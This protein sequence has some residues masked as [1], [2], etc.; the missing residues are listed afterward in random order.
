MSR[1][2]L[3]LAIT[4]GDPAGVG[5]EL[6]L[7]A[8]RQ[9]KAEDAAFF[10]LAAPGAMSAMA[11]RVNLE[12]PIVETDPAGASSVI[13]RGVPVVPLKNPVGA[14]PGRPDSRNAA[15]TIE[16]I[17]RAVEAVRRGEARALVTNPIAKSVLYESGFKFPDTRNFSASSQAIGAARR[18]R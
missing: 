9:R 17:T 16:S 1:D 12:T 15:A 6:T 5:L 10:I 11:R 4:M 18:F 13:E 2:R 8:W 7:S 14:E 3:P